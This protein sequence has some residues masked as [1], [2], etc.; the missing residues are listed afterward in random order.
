MMYQP[1]I[2]YQSNIKYILKIMIYC[3]KVSQMF[4]TVYITFEF[5][6]YNK[7]LKGIK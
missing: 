2:L 6:I 7:K 5:L 3:L 1:G 4:H